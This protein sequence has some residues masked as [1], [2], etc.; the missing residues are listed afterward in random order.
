[1]SLERRVIPSFLTPIHPFTVITFAFGPSP[2]LSMV[3]RRAMNDNHDI[4]SFTMA[5]LIYFCD[6]GC[7]KVPSTLLAYKTRMTA[8]L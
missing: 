5:D 1:M 8:K 2:G 6:R 7:I 3:N 4:I